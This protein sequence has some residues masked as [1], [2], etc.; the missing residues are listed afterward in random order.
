MSPR[1]CHGSGGKG[2]AKRPGWSSCAATQPIADEVDE[3]RLRDWYPP[4]DLLP[5]GVETVIGA[6]SALAATIDRITHDT[7]LNS[8]RRH[9]S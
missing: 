2:S 5:D 7:G 3:T 1:S 8:L 9:S 6:D 4:L